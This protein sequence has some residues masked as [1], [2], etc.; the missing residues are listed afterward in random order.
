MDSVCHSAAEIKTVYL[1]EKKK[2][3]YPSTV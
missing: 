2:G 1:L 3:S